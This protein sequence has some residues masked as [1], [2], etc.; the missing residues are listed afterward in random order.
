MCGI[1][2]IIH[3]T[4]HN[5]LQEQISIMCDA[6]SHRGPDDMGYYLDGPLALGHRRLSI[7]DL[8]AEGHQPMLYADKYVI[9]YNGEIYNYI[10]IRQNLEQLGYHF[11][12]QSDTEVILAAY[13]QWGAECLQK[14]NG[15]WAFAL[16]DKSNYTLFC[17]RDRFGVKPFYIADNQETFAFGSEIKQLLPYL[18]ERKVNK[19]VLADYLYLGLEEHSAET[20]FE[21]VV[22]LQPSH[23]LIYDLKTHTFETFRYFDI[24]KSKEISTE[25]SE[26]MF[27]E[28]FTDAVK[29]RLRSDVK[30]GT[31]L[32]GGLDSSTIATVAA[33]INDQISQTKFVAVTARSIETDNDESHF[34]KMVVENSGLDW[35][36]TTPSNA[37]FHKELDRIIAVQEEPFR[38]TSIAFQYFVMKLSREIGCTVLLD[39]QGG[40]EILLGY[41]RYQ[42]LHFYSLLKKLKLRSFFKAMSQA[43]DISWKSLV[44][45]IIYYKSVPLRKRFI[46]KKMPFIKWDETQ[47][48]IN[49]TLEKFMSHSTTLDKYIHAELFHFNLP[50][51]LKYEDKNSM[52]FSIETRL[53]FLDFRLVDLCYNLKLE[54]K[55]NG[56]WTKYTLRSAFNNV[57]PS[58]ISWRKDKKGFISPERSW[59]G[60][61]DE[62]M[63]SDIKTSAILKGF[64]QFKDMEDSFSQLDVNTKWK[65]FNIAKW[66]KT[67]NVQFE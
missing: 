45:N 26:N 66:E 41:T 52:A 53:P 48:Y 58:A 65:L 56:S 44:Q 23:Y 18:E 31:C 35:N 20:F 7:L 62:Q 63:L 46:R 8:S 2:G 42:S 14:F 36:I 37:D 12:S 61:M 34:A 11:H 38:S 47:V 25:Q 30:V 33:K 55:L 54:K 43:T 21:G 3:K 5:A 9:V 4:E 22:K 29:L 67:Y 1:A 17:A 50:A 13:A 51:L 60:N 49:K 24:V 57:V 16:Y 32:S 10:E 64:T 6:V 39:G 19:Q 15:M 40:D 59:L 28:L 27:R